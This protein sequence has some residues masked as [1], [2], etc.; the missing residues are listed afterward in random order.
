MEE[1]DSSAAV[2]R[3]ISTMNPTSILLLLFLCGSTLAKQVG[4]IIMNQGSLIRW[5]ALDAH[6]YVSKNVVFLA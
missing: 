1:G 5:V 3:L 6:Q 2:T 4:D